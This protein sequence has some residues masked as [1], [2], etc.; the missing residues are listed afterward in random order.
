MEDQEFVTQGLAWAV[1]MVTMEKFASFP[2]VSEFLRQK[3]HARVTRTAPT[4]V[5]AQACGSRGRERQGGWRQLQPMVTS[6]SLLLSWA[7]VT[8]S[9]EETS[10]PGRKVREEGLGQLQCHLSGEVR[11]Q[12][13][14]KLPLPRHRGPA[15]PQTK[16]R[17]PVFCSDSDL[18]S[19]T[20]AQELC[21]KEVE[22]AVTAAL[23]RAELLLRGGSPLPHLCT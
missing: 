18:R 2:S 23:F 10:V 4:Q 12:G 11:M 22:G 19:C 15:C 20:H 5:E 6:S 16:A 9:L 8:Q 14:P 17:Q 7:L 3:R 21:G 13:H 1:V